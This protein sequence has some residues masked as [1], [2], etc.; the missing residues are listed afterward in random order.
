MR[1]PYLKGVP[2]TVVAAIDQERVIAC[3]RLKQTTDADVFATF[4]EEDLVPCL[5]SVAK[6]E[7]RSVV[8]MD[9]ASVHMIDVIQPLIE[10][11]GA[12]LIM[13]P[14]YSPDANPIEEVFSQVKAYLKRT[15]H[16]RR[17]TDRDIAEAFCSVSTKAI[18]GH[19]RN[20]GYPAEKV[21]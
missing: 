20:C 8:V 3:R 5:G 4:I 17:V 18:R 21:D 16:G 6:S 14:T 10:A 9:N 2:Y 1:N 7:P 15:C 19:F 13:L 12:M 11:A